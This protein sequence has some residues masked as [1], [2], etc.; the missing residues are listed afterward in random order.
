M[1]RLVMDEYFCAPRSTLCYSSSSALPV[2]VSDLGKMA[3][4]AFSSRTVSTLML[5]QAGLART[6]AK[7]LLMI[8][9][10][11]SNDPNLSVV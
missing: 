11:V 1:T 7:T 4:S 10:A 9:V 6:V 5:L 8:S 2:S 3:R